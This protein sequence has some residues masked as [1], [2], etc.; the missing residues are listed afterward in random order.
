MSNENLAI[1][2]SSKLTFC[3]IGKSKILINIFLIETSI[4]HWHKEGIYFAILVYFLNIFGER[5]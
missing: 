2:R 4:W 3:Y 1:N 5:L